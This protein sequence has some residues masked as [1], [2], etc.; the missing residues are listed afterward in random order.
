MIA[1]KAIMGDPARSG[2]AFAWAGA[3]MKTS[4]YIIEFKLAK[5]FFNK[6]YGTVARYARK[7]HD[8]IKPNIM[9]IEMNYRGKKILPLF[10]G[11]YKMPWMVGVNTA[12][13]LKPETRALGYTMDKNFMIEWFQDKMKDHEIKF[14]SMP[15]KDMQELID[16]IPKISQFITPGGKTSYRA[17]R[18]QHDDL[19]MCAL[20]VCNVMRLFIDQQESLK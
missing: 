7:I 19:F 16:Q 11:K 14:P 5:Q 8:E 12:T 10:Q 18:G 1:L 4:D 20:L 2:D 15:T 9:G 3:Q 6:P 13:G 17:Y